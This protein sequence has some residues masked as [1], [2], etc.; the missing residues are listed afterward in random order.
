V[1]GRE[2]AATSCPLCHG[3]LRPG[4]ERTIVPV[5]PVVWPGVAGLEVHAG[6]LAAARRGAFEIPLRRGAVPVLAAAALASLLALTLLL[7]RALLPGEGWLIPA[8]ATLIL[9]PALGVLALV[10]AARMAA[11]EDA[12]G[13]RTA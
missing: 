5:S 12:R 11:R 4:D 9:A 7:L 8:V 6:C 1:P 2:R 13:G 3:R 10:A